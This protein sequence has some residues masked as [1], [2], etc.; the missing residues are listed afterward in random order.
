MMRYLSSV[1]I[2]IGPALAN[3]LWQSTGFLVAVWL[4]T[5]ALRRNEA[6]VRY[7]LWIAA[8]VKFLLP[9]SLLTGLGRLL[10][11]PRHLEVQAPAPVASAIEIASR[12][13]SGFIS[14]SPVGSTPHAARLIDPA[15]PWVPAIVAVVW[16][17]GAATV[18]LLWYRRWRQVAAAR[19][20]AVP[21]EQG[22]ELNILRRLESTT[23]STA[24]VALLHSREA[25]E[26]GIF[27]IFRPALLWPQMLSERL[28]DEHIEAILAHELSHARR[29]DNLAAALHM[30]VEAVFWFHPAVWW[31]ETRMLDERERACDEAVI[32][33]VTRP[34]IYAESLLMTC[35]FCVESPS[36]CAAGVTGADLR[37]RVA[38]ILS[39]AGVQRLSAHRKLLLGTA[40]LLALAVPVAFG[41]L[42]P[43]QTAPAA[44]QAAPAKSPLSGPAPDTTDPAAAKV[45]EFAVA[46]IKPDKSGTNM[47]RI[48]FGPDGFTATNV[49]L[50][51]LI[52]EAFS[53]N[54]DQI[55]GEPAWVSSTSFDVDAK[56]DS[57]DVPAMKN[58]TF[59]QRR[60]MIRS[61]LA[62]RFALKTH[63]ETKELPVY[64]LVIAKGGPKL[65]EAKPGDTYPN[66]LNGPDGQHGGAGMMMFNASG[67]ITAQGVLMSNLTRLLSQQTGRTVIDKTGLMG[68]YDFTLQMPPMKGPMPMPPAAGNGPAGGDDGGDDSSGPSIFTALQEQLGLKLDSQKAPLPLIVIDH[69]E[70]PSAN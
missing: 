12:P 60:Q 26:P 37:S 14:A 52:R 46:S 57:A 25:M 20:R 63:E 7:W 32:R 66:G 49:P 70:Q 62:D 45:P 33:S 42:H 41:L 43:A 59:D 36:L 30:V 18:A 53:V 55:A 6:R 64:M 1:G 58:L 5:L 50:K 44:V 4:L 51:H 47:F 23:R 28:Q 48:M 34:D 29:H 19:R 16:L 39:G 56:V 11:G 22:R 67:Q 69:I 3:H 9:F 27:G 17:C 13:F 15:M 38:R 31:M 54:D 65:H 21:V 35:R 61:L 24:R 2:D 8:S 10:P 68:K 40:A